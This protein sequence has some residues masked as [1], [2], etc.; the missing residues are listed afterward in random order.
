MDDKE[1]QKCRKIIQMLISLPESGI[2][3]YY[4]ILEQFRESLPHIKDEGDN[5]T[6]KFGLN[7]ILV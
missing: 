4:N 1:I 3:K 6:P 5:T 7:M 2:F